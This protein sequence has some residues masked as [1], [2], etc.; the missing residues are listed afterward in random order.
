MEA[1]HVTGFPFILIRSRYGQARIQGVA[2]KT[3]PPIGY[4]FATDL[5]NHK[6]SVFFIFIG[7]AINALTSPSSLMA[8]QTSPSE[9]K[10]LSLKQELPFAASLN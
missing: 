4:S 7:S 1:R 3:I 6:K 10:A 8:V 5:E 2:K 9:K